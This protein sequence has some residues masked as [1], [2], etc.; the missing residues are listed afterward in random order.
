[1][2]SPI[3]T[4]DFIG[5][6]GFDTSIAYTDG[7]Y[8]N[9]GNVEADMSY[10]G[11]QNVRSGISDGSGGS[12]PISSYVDLAQHGAKFTFIV[13][14]SGGVYTTATLQS[15]LAM[16]DQVDE[17]VPGSVAA[18]EGPNE[19]NNQALTYNGEG[20]EQGAIDLQRDLYAMVHAD[21]N[22]SGAKVDYFTGYATVGNAIGPNP[23]AT[24]GLADFDN[25]HP[26]PNFGQAPAFWVDPS[27]A[28][29][30]ESA[31]FGPFVYTETGYS[32]NGGAGGA[33][34]ADVQGKYALD[35]LMD[36]AKAGSSMTFLYQLLDAYQPGSPQG[37]DGFGLFD[38]A[39][40]PKP[41]ATGIHN[42]VAILADASAGA[43][44][45][46]PVA[47]AYSVNGLSSS[48][49]S[50]AM[51]KADGTQEVVVW[52]EKAIWNNQTGTEIFPPATTATVSLGG[53]YGAVYVYDPLVA[54]TPIA[55]YANIGAVPLTLGASP[56]IIEVEPQP[57][58]PAALTSATTGPIVLGSGPDTLAVSVSEDA[59]QGDAQFTFAMD[60]VQIGGTQ[61]ATAT[62]AAGASQTYDIE[63][64][65]A[66]SHTATVTFLNDAWAGTAQ[67]DRNL[68]VN[69]VTIDHSTVSNATLA[70]LSGGPQSF[71]FQ[72]P[73]RAG[74]AV[75]LDM[76]E[77]AWQGDAQYTIAVDGVQYGGIGTETAIRGLGQHD[78]VSVGNLSAGAH[79][80]AVDFLNDAW[81]GTPQ[82]DRNL[83][84]DDATVAG[85]TQS[86][87]SLTLL[88]GGTQYLNVVVPSP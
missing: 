66:G 29:P 3:R 32:T 23:A 10:L 70:L 83:Y 72:G 60:G 9:I 84:V 50:L 6:L 36:A 2:T 53:T 49:N 74:Q 71:S 8:A 88:G 76:S 37:D 13:G 43:A 28:L 14:A 81:G 65:F 11:I 77:D 64:N 44:S 24:P 26:Y 33:V 87:T 78:L 17:A 57:A 82:T 58:P 59:W 1:M 39:N 4:Q 21:A 34:N 19:I 52:D 61:T 45:F 80:I 69:G 47:S 62:R 7:G 16:F 56:L 73:A 40:N 68:Y 12:A 35:L 27:F 25:Q 20:G 75:A 38:T 63:G 67:T 42:L 48:G 5:S 51:E 31:P 30:N 79:Q 54:A 41:A 46:A 18:V 85:T 86:N 22:V 55:S 15:Q